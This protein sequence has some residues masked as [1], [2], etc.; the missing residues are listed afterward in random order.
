MTL[1]TS[2]E[3]AVGVGF[4]DLSEASLKLTGKKVVKEKT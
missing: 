4:V 2:Q 1:A 3:L